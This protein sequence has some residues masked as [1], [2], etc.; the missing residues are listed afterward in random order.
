MLLHLELENKINLYNHSEFDGKTVNT[1]DTT[2]VNSRNGRQKPLSQFFAE[3][4][5]LLVERIVNTISFEVT[6]A[7]IKI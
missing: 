5:N 7:R 3:F 2:G 1:G 4:T 6:L